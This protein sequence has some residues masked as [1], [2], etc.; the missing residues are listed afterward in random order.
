MKRVKKL[1]FPEIEKQLLIS[2]ANGI[3]N[4]PYTNYIEFKKECEHIIEQGKFP[5]FQKICEEV[6]DDRINGLHFHL[7]KNCPID[8]EIPNLNLDDSVNEKYKKKKSFVGE[9]FLLIYSMLSDSPILGYETRNNGDMY[10]DVLAINK[11]TNTQT[12]K[13]DGDLFFHNDRTAHA[14]RADYLSLL[15]LRTSGK[16]KIY[17]GFID[18]Q[19][20]LDQLDNQTQ[21]ILREPYFV[22]PF[23]NYSKDSNTTQIR[24]ENHSIL[25]NEQSFRY[26]DCR[27]TWATESPEK[28]K[29]AL[30][31]LKNA[32]TRSDKVFVDIQD[33]DLFTFANLKGLHSRFKAEINSES[34]SKNRW[35]LKTYNFES[36]ESLKTFQDEYF[37]N[38]PG[39][40]QELS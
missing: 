23:D 4:S 40:V 5:N 33:N 3:G 31:A 34:E 7:I 14:I 11:Y 18:G 8:N 30:I 1:V 21:D 19:W 25:F 24:S 22:T 16:N 20:I 13:T 37:E 36:E 27:T 28:A 39:L 35:L 6:K 2:M 26:Y 32:I 15:G 9:A 10:Q 12:Q 38:I 29:E 17:T